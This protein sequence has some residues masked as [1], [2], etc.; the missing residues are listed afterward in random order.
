M[1]A[2]IR[3]RQGLPYE[4]SLQPSFE[5]NVEQLVAFSCKPNP[6]ELPVDAVTLAFERFTHPKLT[7]LINA[8]E[9]VHRQKALAM[10]DKLCCAPTEVAKFLEVGVVQALNKATSD[11]DGDVRVLASHVLLLVAREKAGRDHMLN[12]GTIIVLQRLLFD[13]EQ[14]VRAHACQALAAL[15]IE[16]KMTEEVVETGTV[17]HLVE[18]TKHENDEVMPHTLYALKMCLMHMQGLT[19]AIEVGAISAMASLLSSHSPAVREAACQNLFCL[20]VPMDGKSSCLDEGSV[21]GLFPRLVELLLEPYSH[22]QA[23]AAAALMAMSVS[24]PAKHK[25]VECNAC[26]ALA[27]LLVSEEVSAKLRTN[28]IKLI[29]LLGES[30][31]GRAALMHVVPTLE[32]ISEQGR[33][34][35]PDAEHAALLR[36][37]AQRALAIITWTP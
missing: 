28:I 29:S 21:P 24:I 37:H 5:S 22:V 30:P 25:A 1:W 2:V 17:A 18:R 11:S 9:L 15:C 6:Q 35:P 36:A 20:A 4:H 16:T 26:E 27:K 23:E 13:G 10:I 3:G 19:A 7:K 14:Q 34:A 32:E 33:F 8:D 31:K 12:A